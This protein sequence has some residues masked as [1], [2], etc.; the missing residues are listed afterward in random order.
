MAASNQALKTLLANGN[1]GKALEQLVRLTEHTDDRDL[2]QRVLTL[3]GQFTALK[4]QHLTGLLEGK[5]YRLQLNR[6]TAAVADI[7]ETPVNG[8]INWKK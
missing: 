3:S 7:I 6:I 1:V 2:L 8:S 4:N 5:D